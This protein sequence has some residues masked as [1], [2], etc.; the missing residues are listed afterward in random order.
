MEKLQLSYD[1]KIYEN[2][3]YNYSGFSGFFRNLFKYDKSDWIDPVKK[4][5]YNKKIPY[6]KYKEYYLQDLS[7]NE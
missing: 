4:T 5:L 1:R 2:N 6:Q 3:P 7:H